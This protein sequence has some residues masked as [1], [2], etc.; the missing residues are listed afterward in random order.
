MNTHMHPH[1]PAHHTTEIHFQV[2]HVDNGVAYEYDATR[3]M[4]SAGNV[5][6]KLRVATL[7]KRGEI[8]VDLYAGCVFYPAVTVPTSWR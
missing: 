7:G 8:V 6:E 2:H 4:F 1:I 3:C 5:T